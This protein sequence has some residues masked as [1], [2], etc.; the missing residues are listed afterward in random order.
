MKKLQQPAKKQTAKQKLGKLGE[1]LAKKFLQNKGYRLI[2]ENFYTRF[3]EIDLIFLKGSVLIFVEVKT[4]SS[5]V[6]GLPIQA[7]SRKKLH[8]IY[9]AAELFLQKNPQYQKYQL[10]IDAIS[11][12]KSQANFKIKHFQN[13]S[14]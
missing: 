6:K 1:K 12:L 9:L 3:G 2:S 4:R 13:I 11:I 8:N 7:I 5:L 10:R 14:F